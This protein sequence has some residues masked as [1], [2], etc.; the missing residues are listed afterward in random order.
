MSEPLT[1]HLTILLTDIKG[2][3]DKTSHKSRAD[4]NH[5]LDEHRAVVLPVLEARGGRLIKTIGDAYMLT[6]DSPTNAVLA[7]VDVQKALARRNVHPEATGGPQLPLVKAAKAYDL[8][9]KG[10]TGKVCIV[11]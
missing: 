11:F 3:T 7:G 10:Q 1:R 9:N 6:F 8:A 5:M 4:I 2:F